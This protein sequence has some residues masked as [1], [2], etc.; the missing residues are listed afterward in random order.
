MLRHG[1]KKTVVLR[2]PNS[3]RPWQHVLEPLGGYLML[4][5]KLYENRDLHGESFNFGPSLNKNFTVLDVVNEIAI[6]WNDIKFITQSNLEDDFH[7]CNLFKLN[8]DKALQYLNWSS[9]LNF[10]QTINYT[11]HWYMKYYE[12]PCNIE[13]TT[14]IQ[15]SEYFKIFNNKNLKV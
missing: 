4:A 3:T 2:R 6:N 9:C 10:E 7:E 11:S 15:I 13:E 8:C 12:N 14:K 5:N 1:Q